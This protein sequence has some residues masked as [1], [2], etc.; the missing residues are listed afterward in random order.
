VNRVPSCL[1]CAMLHECHKHLLPAT[2]E[3]RK[4]AS[5]CRLPARGRTTELVSVLGRERK[6][7]RKKAVRLAS[8]DKL[9][10]VDDSTVM[11]LP[12]AGE[13]RAAMSRAL[14]NQ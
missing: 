8:R 9:Q 6:M 4:I 14:R 12:C 7:S 2:I 3:A 13:T 5:E 1:A 10:W 11:L